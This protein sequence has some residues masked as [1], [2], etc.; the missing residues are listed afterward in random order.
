MDETDIHYKKMD[1]YLSA[2]R[3]M[4]EEEINRI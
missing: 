4:I 1:D 3:E 2:I